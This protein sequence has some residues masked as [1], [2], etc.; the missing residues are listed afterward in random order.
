VPADHAT[1]SLLQGC[2]QTE[3]ILQA[4]LVLVNGTNSHRKAARSALAQSKVATNGVDHTKEAGSDGAPTQMP[5]PLE[6]VVHAHH[7]GW[8]TTSFPLGL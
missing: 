8:G 6:N 4:S 7:A 3:S 1:R 2:L 5:P